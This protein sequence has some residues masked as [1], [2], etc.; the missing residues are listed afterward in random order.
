MIAQK[1][2]E[3]SGWVPGF[4]HRERGVCKR[5]V[6]AKT[7]GGDVRHGLES[8][9]LGNHHLRSSN[10]AFQILVNRSTR[11]SELFLLLDKG[12][13]SLIGLSGMTRSEPRVSRMCFQHFVSSL[14]LQQFGSI[15]SALII[16]PGDGDV[17]GNVT[18][19]CKEG[20]PT[21]ARIGK[22]IGGSRVLGF[23]RLGLKRP[24]CGV[25]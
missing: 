1:Q 11:G 23:F 13:G 4:A 20:A 16:C 24:P 7:T 6:D 12:V 9:E 18:I 10:S 19:I 21:P 5:R 25:H 2:F 8:L 17:A 15:S 3:I 14:C 22:W